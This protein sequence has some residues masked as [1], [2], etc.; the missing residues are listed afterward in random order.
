M[1]KKLIYLSLFLIAIARGERAHADQTTFYISSGDIAVSC[2]KST[3][4]LRISKLKRYTKS[5]TELFT[6]RYGSVGVC[7]AV[8]NL[9]TIQSSTLASIE[10]TTDSRTSILQ[11]NPCIDSQ[12]SADELSTLVET[13]NLQIK[14]AS[15]SMEGVVPGSEHVEKLTW[16]SQFCPPFK[17]DCDL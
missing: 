2:S 1:T 15:F 13:V 16:N 7:K 12:C 4:T 17:P 11:I 14:E 8:Q 5:N 9:L 3:L 6:E 10:T